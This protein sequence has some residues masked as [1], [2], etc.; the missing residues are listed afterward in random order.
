M[1]VEGMGRPS[2]TTSNCHFHGLVL[3]DAID[4]TLRKEIRNV[5]STTEDLK[6]DRDRGVGPRIVVDVKIRAILHM[7]SHGEDRVE[8]Q[9][10]NIRNPS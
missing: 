10:N 6:K 9:I 2:S 1:Q 8:S 5:G 3:I 4:A 7:S